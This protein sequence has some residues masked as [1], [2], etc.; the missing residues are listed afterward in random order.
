MHLSTIQQPVSEPFSNLISLAGSAGAVR[1]GAEDLHG[2]RDV[3]EP[4]V[5]FSPVALPGR[6]QDGKPRHLTSSGDFTM[7]TVSN[8]M[9]R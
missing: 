4:Y 2:V 7:K 5:S 1:A 9:E 8:K 3:G 6:A